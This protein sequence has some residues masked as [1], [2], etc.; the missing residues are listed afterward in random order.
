[1][2]STVRVAVEDGIGTVT[3][4][5]PE[6]LNAVDAE[7]RE[8]IGA[9]LRA[10]DADDGVRAIVLTGAGERA[11]TA[12]QDLH[13]LVGFDAE[14]GAA[15]VRALGRLY[16]AIRELSKPSVVAMNGIASGA[17]LQMA[18]HAD[19]RVAH[20]GVRMTQPE[21]NAGLP[22]VL[23]PWIMRE[24]IGFGRT[25]ELALTGRLADAEECRGAGMIDHLV[26]ADELMA[27]ALGV[28]SGLG[29]Q[30]PNA[31]RLTKAR[32]RALTQAS[33]DATIEAGAALAREAF[34][35]G[36]PQRVAAAFL[37]ERA[38]RRS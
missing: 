12:G 17:G 11:F 15:W 26:P 35:D 13:E 30:P 4:N 5:R 16:Q 34:A 37:A 23:G 27:K 24:T 10:L 36:E 1:V 8:G 7:M 9:A 3:L 6:V 29:R 19:V 32:T 31:V 2:T 25:R 18:L 28:A 21:I 14:T 22:S 38:R 20:P 33:W